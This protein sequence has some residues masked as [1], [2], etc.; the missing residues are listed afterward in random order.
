MSKSLIK[1]NEEDYKLI[2]DITIKGI[3]KAIEFKVNYG[4]QLIDPW[5]N[6]RAGFTIDGSIDRF[7]FGLNWN[8]LLEAGSAIVGKLVKLQAEIEIVASK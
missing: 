5:G 7:D 3:T 2:G 6:T 8:S 4:G 1:L